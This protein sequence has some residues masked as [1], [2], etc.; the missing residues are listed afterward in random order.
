MATSTKTIKN[1]V[2]FLI[3][4]SSLN[5]KNVIYEEKV[6]SVDSSSYLLKFNYSEGNEEVKNVQILSDKKVIGTILPQ[7]VLEAKKLSNSE[8]TMV[9]KQ[10]ESKNPTAIKQ[11]FLENY[12]FGGKKWIT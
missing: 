11:L 1:K 8:K 4:D 9:E 5:I 10:V 7:E 3:L 12:F 2:H 6:P